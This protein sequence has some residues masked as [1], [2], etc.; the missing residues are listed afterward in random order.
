MEHED[1]RTLVWAIWNLALTVEDKGSFEDRAIKCIDET[2][3]I[4]SDIIPPVILR[5]PVGTQV[6]ENGIKQTITR[7][8]ENFESNPAY[9]LDENNDALYIFEDF[10]EVI[11]K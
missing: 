3:A 4:S 5:L 2:L 11:S 7:N 8:D 9:R 10:D 6:I 1:K